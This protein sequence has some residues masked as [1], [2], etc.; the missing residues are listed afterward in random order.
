MLNQAVICEYELFWDAIMDTYFKTASPSKITIDISP[1]NKSTLDKTTKMIEQMLQTTHNHLFFTSLKQAFDNLGSIKLSFIYSGE[2]KLS[3]MMKGFWLFGFLQSA[4]EI[5][6][7]N[8]SYHNDI[9]LKVYEKKCDNK[10][11]Q[12]CEYLINFYK[13]KKDQQKFQKY[14]KKACNLGYK[15]HCNTKSEVDIYVN[16]KLKNLKIK[17][18]NNDYN[19]CY[20]LGYD[21]LYSDKVQKNE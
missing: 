16:T 11:Y 13:D 9:V 7:N 18:D 3:D 6:I 17:C 5:F 19:A 4:D 20:Q 21:L 14:L 1:Q 12:S 2:H 10:D 15:E 8:R